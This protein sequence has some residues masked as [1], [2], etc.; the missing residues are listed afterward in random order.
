[1]KH[2][3]LTLLLLCPLLSQLQAQTP[4]EERLPWVI[5][6]SETES[7]L[8]FFIRFEGRKISWES[9]RLRLKPGRV[10]YKA[11][12]Q[13]FAILTIDE[14]NDTIPYFM[15]SPLRI[16]TFN[17][18]KVN[19]YRVYRGEIK[20]VLP[21]TGKAPRVIVLDSGKEILRIKPEEISYWID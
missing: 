21:W 3:L 1:M 12:W 17:D 16:S 11:N 13:D 9:E 8:Y 6:P 18:G 10:T 4:E 2:A 15:P 7:Y 14:N 19:T 20:F 5:T